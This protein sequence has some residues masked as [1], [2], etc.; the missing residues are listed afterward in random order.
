MASSSLTILNWNACSLASKKLELVEFLRTANIDLAAITETHLKP[1]VGFNLPDH[2]IVRL[3]R[4]SS[5][6]GG[7]AIA[8][9]KSISFKVLPS[10]NTTFIEA[11]GV[12]VSSNN[13]SFHFAAVYCQNNLESVTIRL[14]GSE[15]TCRNYLVAV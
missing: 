11:L 2:V 10:F 1:N 15:M 4:T 12:E 5:G 14:S 7:V 9:R 3:D 6:G 8:V 13:G